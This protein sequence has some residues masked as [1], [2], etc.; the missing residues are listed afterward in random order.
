MYQSKTRI[1]TVISGEDNLFYIR[2]IVN[3]N[4]INSYILADS[5]V[6]AETLSSK[7]QDLAK[8]MYNKAY[9]DGFRDCQNNIK[10]TLGIKVI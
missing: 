10:T 9:N 7:L 6:H 1:K 4:E 8:K 2:I 3:G 5:I